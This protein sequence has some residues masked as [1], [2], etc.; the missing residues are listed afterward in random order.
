MVVFCRRRQTA[1][2]PFILALWLFALFVS[3]VRAC[4]LDDDLRHAG[5]SQAAS[6][7]GHDGTDDGASSACDKFY[8]DDLAVLGKLKAVQDPPTG[9][10]FVAPQFVVDESVQFLSSQVTG[11]R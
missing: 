7:G 9:H 8:S 11:Q 10:A 1:I 2:A 4:G 3:V 6:V 5:H